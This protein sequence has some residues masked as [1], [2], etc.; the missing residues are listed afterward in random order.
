MKNQVRSNHKPRSR[1]GQSQNSAAARRPGK[2]SK[3][4]TVWVHFLAE[5][6]PLIDQA[7]AM[8]GESRDEFIMNAVQEKIDRDAKV[9]TLWISL[10]E[11]EI[12]AMDSACEKEGVSRQEL[13]ERMIREHLPAI[14]RTAGQ[15]TAAGEGGAQ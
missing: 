2:K 5:I 1:R 11:W 4:E 9:K 13:F 15:G 3:L 7:A 10:P 6:V 14:E 12:A 8:E